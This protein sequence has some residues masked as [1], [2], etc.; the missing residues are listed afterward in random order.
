MKIF[1]ENVNENINLLQTI[2]VP[3]NLLYLT[4]RL[5]TSNYEKFNEKSHK[6][7]SFS[8][9]AKN[10]NEILPDIKITSKRNVIKS[11]RE[12]EGNSSQS[13][14][15]NEENSIN[16]SI[17]IKEVN[18]VSP[19]I[20]K[21][22]NV[23]PVYYSIEHDQGRGL[24]IENRG[25][26]NKNKNNNLVLNNCVNNDLTL[27]PK[28]NNK[29]DLSLSPVN[30]RSEKENHDNNKKKEESRNI[31][32]NEKKVKMLLQKVGREVSNNRGSCGPQVLNNRNQVI[33]NKYQKNKRDNSYL[34]IG[35]PKNS[36]NYDYR[37]VLE[38]NKL[39][40]IQNSRRMR[41]IQYKL[42]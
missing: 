34:Q 23:K 7:Q 41:V 42:I 35:S 18:I 15:R 4:D 27:L 39:P 40:I 17:Q 30:Y 2:R 13:P 26:Y 11:K 14:V 6:H 28:I 32:Y 36:K 38:Y 37:Q 10:K 19:M 3:N 25:R 9:K 5:P 31:V 21:E 12:I 29:N 16:N 22:E 33:M 20:K 1:E 8:N 24:S